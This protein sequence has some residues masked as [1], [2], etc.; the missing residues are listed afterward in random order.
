MKRPLW[1]TVADEQVN[2]VN[3][4]FSFVISTANWRH[5]S[6][7]YVAEGRVVNPEIDGQIEPARTCETS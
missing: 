5:T 6:L 2:S 3:V 7:C 1:V 4:D